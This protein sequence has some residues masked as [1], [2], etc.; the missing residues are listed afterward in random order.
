[1]LTGCRGHLYFLLRFLFRINVLSLCNKNEYKNKIMHRLHITRKRFYGISNN[2]DVTCKQLE[3]CHLYFTCDDLEER[4][5][6]DG[7]P[8]MSQT[9]TWVEDIP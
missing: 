5:L 6:C 8:A 7:V 2:F 4:D 1:M 9:R 3:S